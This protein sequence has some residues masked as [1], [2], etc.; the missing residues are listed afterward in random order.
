MECGRCASGLLRRDHIP[1]AA[2]PLG[3]SARVSSCG[4]GEDGSARRQGGVAWDFAGFSS[5]DQEEFAPFFDAVQ[6][7]TP[8]LREVSE[9]FGRT[10]CGGVSFPWDGTTGTVPRANG[11][12]QVGIPV[13]TDPTL[14]SVTLLDATAVG[15]L[16]DAALTNVLG[17]GVLQPVRKESGYSFYPLPDIPHLGESLIW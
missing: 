15:R 11:L 10:P 13:A 2:Q 5:R 8:A 14:A 7:A 1:H 3:A 17:G 16:T 12:V 6:R 4:C 9:T